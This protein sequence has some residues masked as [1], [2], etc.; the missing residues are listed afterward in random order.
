M[1]KIF[2]L[3]G[4]FLAALLVG[5]A[6]SYQLVPM[7]NQSKS[8]DDPRKGRIYV[9]RPSS[10][11]SAVQMSIADGGNP[12]GKTGP[13]SYLCWEREPGDVIVSATSENTS[14][15]SLP[16]RPGSIHYI[17]QYMRMGMWVARNELNVV[18]EEVGQKELKRCKPAEYKKQ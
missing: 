12:I 9:I 2:T 7:P 10:L 3:A 11:G 4:C 16:V 18:T 6:S 8:I 17:V 1:N 15:V 5:C 13:A 14:R